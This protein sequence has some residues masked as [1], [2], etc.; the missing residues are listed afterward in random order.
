MDMTTVT[1]KVTLLAWQYFWRVT[2]G[3]FKHDVFFRLIRPG[4]YRWS[5]IILADT[6]FFQQSDSVSAADFSGR[7][8][9]PSTFYQI[10][11][12]L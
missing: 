7:L 12:S 4:I 10:F 11:I 5:T 8:N 6:D 3:K 9:R 2:K 1:Q